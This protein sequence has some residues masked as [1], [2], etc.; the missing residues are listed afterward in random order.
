MTEIEALNAKLKEAKART[1]LVLK[2]RYGAS[3]NLNMLPI[4]DRKRL[5]NLLI[6]EQRYNISLEHILGILFDHY[7]QYGG[8]FKL[9]NSRRRMRVRGLPTSAKIL[10]GKN[11]EEF[12]QEYINELYPHQEHVV[13]KKQMEQDRLVRRQLN[14]EHLIV[15]TK[16]IT[17]YET[18]DS[19]LKAYDAKME[20]LFGKMN[21]MRMYLKQNTRNYRGSPWR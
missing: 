12:L 18:L 19:Y 4:P 3:R 15:E 5:Y 10:M 11:S 20:K 13:L 8:V 21:V 9:Q 16:P 6:W 7:E 14:R 1:E 17:E 2:Q